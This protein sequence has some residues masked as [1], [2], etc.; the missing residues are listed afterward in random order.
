[1]LP[2]LNAVFLQSGLQEICCFVECHKTCHLRILFLSVLDAVPCALCAQNPGKPLCKTT[3]QYTV[4]HT[5][6]SP[7]VSLT[8]ISREA[9]NSEYLLNVNNTIK[10][11]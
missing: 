1:M 11:T 9:R 10:N 6:H 2:L 8:P 3:P 7:T 5:P 4:I